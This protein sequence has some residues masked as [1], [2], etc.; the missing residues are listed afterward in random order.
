[1]ESEEQ[2]RIELEVFDLQ[3]VKIMNEERYLGKIHH[4]DYP[5]GVTVAIFKIQDELIAIHALCPHEAYNLINSEF[6]STY[7]IECAA[8]GNCYTI[9]SGNLI[10]YEV[11]MK[12]DKIFVVR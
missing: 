11:V 9:K 7:E 10:H 4:P 2:A 6:K 1:M 12:D 5:N 3:T 8:H